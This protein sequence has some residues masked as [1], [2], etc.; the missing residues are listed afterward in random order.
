M[1]TKD[2][3]IRVITAL[4]RAMTMGTFTMYYL[5]IATKKFYFSQH[6]E[7]KNRQSR[8]RYLSLLQEAAQ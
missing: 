6:T 5:K 3:I 4:Y 2:Y 8:K 7:E 1:S